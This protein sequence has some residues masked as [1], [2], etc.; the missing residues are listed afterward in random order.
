MEEHIHEV[1]GCDGVYSCVHC[2]KQ[3][4]LKEINKMKIQLVSKK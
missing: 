1:Y 3:F 4:S 2:P